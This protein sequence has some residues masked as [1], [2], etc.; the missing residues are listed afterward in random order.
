M[1]QRTGYIVPN[2]VRYNHSLQLAASAGDWLM[3]H[4]ISM[5][6]SRYFSSQLSSAR[7]AGVFQNIERVLNR[8][9]GLNISQFEQVLQ[10]I[11]SQNNLSSTDALRLLHYCGEWIQSDQWQKGILNTSLLSEYHVETVQNRM[12]LLNRV[13][14]KILDM[15]VPLT[16]AHFNAWLTMSMQNDHEID[17]DLFFRQIKS[18]N[19]EPNRCVR[20]R[21]LIDHNPIIQD[22]SFQRN[23][24]ETRLILL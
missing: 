10:E 18:K 11:D 15:K 4:N 3:E 6:Q 19:L 13:W 9:N 23:H 22:D 20:L 24:P 7:N 21:Q 1:S 12:K 14:R 2:P 16:I 8:R 17:V 5:N